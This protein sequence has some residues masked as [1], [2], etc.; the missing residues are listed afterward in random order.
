[1]HYYQYRIPVK[2]ERESGLWVDRIG[3]GINF[4]NTSP[5]LRI[6]GLFAAVGITQGEGTFYTPESGKVRV[7]ENDVMLIF[8]QTKHFLDK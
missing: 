4:K 8:P 6:L 5:G 7:E 1:M 2:P 3:S